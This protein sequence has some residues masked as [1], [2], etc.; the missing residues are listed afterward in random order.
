MAGDHFGAS[1]RHGF[2][3]SSVLVRAAR[4]PSGGASSENF[5]YSAFSGFCRIP[6]PNPTKAIVPTI[7]I[8]RILSRFLSI[9]EDMA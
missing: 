3:D 8:M 2:V 1:A 7:E 4:T 5:E 9:I 6:T